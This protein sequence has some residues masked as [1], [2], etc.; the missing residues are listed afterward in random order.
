MK[1][2][3]G[4]SLNDTDLS[5]RTRM[6][7]HWFRDVCFN[8][9]RFPPVAKAVLRDFLRF[10]MSDQNHIYIQDQLAWGMVE[11]PRSNA[12]AL[13]YNSKVMDQHSRDYLDELL[14]TASTST[15]SEF[16]TRSL[17]HG[18]SQGH[19]KSKTQYTRGSK[20]T[21]HNLG[22]TKTIQSSNGKLDTL[23]EE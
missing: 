9:R 10:D 11:A 14:E 21:A 2:Y 13:I 8:Y 12:V 15:Y 19:N 7:D 1:S 18:Q 6:L 23:V 17:S 16:N 4:F 3:F 20:L 5:E 22:Q